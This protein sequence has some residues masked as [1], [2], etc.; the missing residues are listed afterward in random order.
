MINV[1]SPI[2]I[3]EGC[4]SGPNFN[5]EN[6]KLLYCTTHKDE[7]MIDVSHKKCKYEHCN[8]I[9]NKNYRGY[10]LRCF[11]Y[12]FPYEPVSR[13]YKV[14]EKH[15][16]DFIKVHFKSYVESYGEKIQG[17]CSKK[18]PDGFIYTFYYY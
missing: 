5:Y 7:N 2:C 11:I 17:G 4:T 9:R 10:C 8:T 14:K 18:K 1:L 6:E 13:N 16:F 3:F 12:T 15:V